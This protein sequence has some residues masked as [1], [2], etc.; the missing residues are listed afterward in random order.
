MTSRLS[1]GPYGTSRK[2]RSTSFLFRSTSSMPTP[3]LPLATDM[4]DVTAACCNA[5]PD[6]VESFQEAEVGL[7][8]VPR[9]LLVDEPYVRQT[10]EHHRKQDP[11]P[12]PCESGSEAEVRAEPE[13]EML[14]ALAAEVE[15]I[16]ILEHLRIP[17][18]TG[19]VHYR[20]LALGNRHAA[21]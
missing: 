3:V 4:P 9:R 15:A 21:E 20:D 6:D 1:P 13:R 5:S 14:L 2:N 18:G 16:R 8:E 11:Q 19:D 7:A 12:H 17:V 10:V